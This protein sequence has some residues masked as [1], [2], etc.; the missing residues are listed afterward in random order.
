MNEKDRGIHELLADYADGLRDGSVPSFLKSLTR[1]EAETITASPD[2]W[3]ATEVL[4]IINGVG[5]SEKVETP[6]IGLFISRVDAGIGSRIKKGGAS[7][8]KSRKPAAERERKLEKRT[9]ETI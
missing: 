9:E 3:E 1:A 7:A 5:F 6:N 4:R 8:R 2:F